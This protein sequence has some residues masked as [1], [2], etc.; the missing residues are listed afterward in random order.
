MSE[1]ENVGGAPQAAPQSNGMATASLILGIC[2]IVLFW[3]WFV[4][5]ICGVLAIIFGVVAKNKIKANPNMG[6]AGAAK[7]GLITGIIGIVIWLIMVIVVAV[8]LTSTVG[9]FEDAMNNSKEWQD[10]MKELENLENN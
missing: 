3:L 7:G 10:A 5:V 6:G 4:G 1:N 9:A 8:F 2:S